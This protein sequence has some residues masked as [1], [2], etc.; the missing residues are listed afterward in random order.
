M[1]SITRMAADTD[2][3]SYQEA[4][5]RLDWVELIAPYV[6]I[7]EY[8]RLCLVN[9][10]FYR[11]L[12]PRLWNDPLATA[13][14]SAGRPV[15]RDIDI[16]WF[17]RFMEHMRCVRQATRLLVTCLDLRRVEAGTSELSLHSL[18]RSLSAY[19]RA[20]PVTFPQLRCIL[21]N[22]HWDVEADDLAVATT[23]D[24]DHDASNAEGPLMLNIPQCQ[25]KIPTAFFS[26]P[27]LHHLVYLDVS[28]MAGSLRKPLEQQRFGPERHPH[29]RVLKVGAREMGDSTAALLVRTFKQQLWSLDLSQNQLTDAVLNDL[30]IF[31]F[32]AE[33]LRTDSHYDVEGRLEIIPGKGTPLFGQFCLIR[34]SHWSATFSHADR[35]LVDA[36]NYT[37][38]VEYTPQEGV[39]TRLNGRTKVQDDSED[40]IR[41]SFSGIPGASSPRRESLHDLGVC[42]SHNGI[43]HLYLGGNS[44]TA[45]GLVR[46]IMASP[47]QLQHLDCDSMVYE[48]H[49]AVRPD[50][51]PS[52]IRV[53][54]LL[55][56]AHAFRPVLSSNLQV[57]RIHHSL[58]TQLL[59]LK[60]RDG[61]VLSTMEN[62]WLAE[63]FLLPRAEMAYPQAF[64]PDMNPRLRLLTLTHIPRWSTGPLIDRL[65]ELLKLAS[66]QER[67]IQDMNRTLGKSRRG[68]ATVVG[69]RHVRLE[70]D[71]DVK[72]ELLEDG[73][74]DG[75][76]KNQKKYVAEET[77]AAKEFSFFDD[78]RFSD[79]SFDSSSPAEVSSS[80]IDTTNTDTTPLTSVVAGP[81][82][83]DHRAVPDQTVSNQ[84]QTQRHSPSTLSHLPRTGDRS[85]P[86]VNGGNEGQSGRLTTG[87]QQRSSS[88]SSR[89]NWNGTEYAVPIWTGPPPPFYDSTEDTPQH[90]HQ[91]V[92][93]AVE[94]YMRNI[95]DRR[96][97]AD[98]VPASPCHVL[99]GVP[100]GEFIWG[101]AWQAIVTRG[102]T[103]AA[104]KRRP[105]KRELMNGMRDVIGE[106][107]AYRRKTRERYE[108]E[109]KRARLNGDG[110][111]LGE[112]H[113]Y[114]GGRLEV[115]R[116]GSEG[117]MLG[118]R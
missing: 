82:A 33:S 25:V 118:W 31:A 73:E 15:N 99:A 100:E 70:F 66:M 113:F 1:D 108:A 93:P 68:P 85:E 6:P 2:L 38:L 51:L 83:D 12:A 69:L 7:R 19:L 87:P 111:R 102:D 59:S 48:I 74:E 50:W 65:I 39:R 79:F 58:V 61:G 117:G 54:G 9:R 13:S 57:L 96:L 55:G 95:L 92:S 80:N 22:R 104:G 30:H 67:A 109:L 116:A 10:R 42:H 78:S 27:Y 114:Y 28:N 44:I 47:G 107:K 103:T 17:Y 64:R 101:A 71:H 90:E 91:E 46:L 29:L 11:H 35:Y 97:C 18:S 76:E 56:A 86:I 94:A 41:R 36:P 52:S 60:G 63:T 75:E 5:R 88:S 105:K 53:S 23:P 112:P 20:V 62:L 110:V 21:L 26:S 77:T 34:E 14:T 49:E 32:P 45:N 106:I 89:G 81:A 98:A 37:R 3:P 16:E 24:T 4:T 72:G 43:T 8:A 84:S 115:V 40:E